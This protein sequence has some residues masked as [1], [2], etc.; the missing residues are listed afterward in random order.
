MIVE[1]K[2]PSSAKKPLVPI[3]VENEEKVIISFSA[4]STHKSPEK[5]LSSEDLELLEELRAQLDE[6][7]ASGDKDDV[8]YLL[9]ELRLKDF[10]KTGLIDISQA[11]AFVCD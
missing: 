10:H 7:M 6:A 2:T 11:Q 4:A 9:Y 1:Q 3:I 5:K 8:A